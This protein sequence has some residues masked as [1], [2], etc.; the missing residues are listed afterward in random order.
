MPA[1]SAVVNVYNKPSELRL[2]LAAL[3]R[4]TFRDFEAV[5]ADDGSGPAVRQ[6]VEE[7]SARYD[8]PIRHAWHEDTGWRRT[9]SLNNGV[10]SAAADYLVF[11]DGDCIPSEY[12]LEDHMRERE[13]RRVLLGRR[14]EMGEGWARTLTM[15]RVLNGAFEHLGWSGFLEGLRKESKR[16]EDSIRITSPLVRRLLLRNV[17]GMLGSNFSLW[18]SDLEAV[19]G[20]DEEYTSYGLEES[21]LQYRLS[22]IGVTGKPMRNVAIQY[23]IWHPQN[24]VPSAM[25]ERFREVQQRGEPRCR[26]GLVTL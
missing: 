21:D 1:L 13:P 24:A 22:L 8:Y 17:R 10:R 15:E 9:A 16:V 18:K 26:R 14:V 6:V 23:H 3:S 2:V 20:F 11:F 25:M 4:Q 7:A 12:F 5:I 19:N